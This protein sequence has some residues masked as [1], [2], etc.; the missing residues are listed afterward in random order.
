MSDKRYIS[1]T[2]FFDENVRKYLDKRPFS[3]KERMNECMIRQWNSTVQKGDTTIVLGDMFSK[4]EVPAEDINGVLHRL[5]GKICLIAGNHDDWIEMPGVDLGRFEWIAE[6]KTTM[7]GDREVLL[8]HYPILFFGKNHIRDK[9]GRLQTYMLH[10][11]VHNGQEAALLY[12]F[13]RKAAGR[14]FT[15]FEGRTEPMICNCINCF[16]GYSDYRPLTLDEWKARMCA[17]KIPYG[18]RT[19]K[20]CRAGT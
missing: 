11:H 3:T 15:T 12:E 10:G 1:D 20:I 4:G 2:H 9:N 14:K 16:C 17:L 13:M 19:E 6:Q 5:K 8:N 7:D 18:A